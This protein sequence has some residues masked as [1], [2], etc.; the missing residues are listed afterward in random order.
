MNS[1]QI[2]CFVEVARQ[3]NFSKAADK[4]YLPQPTVSRYISN[5]EE[6]LGMQLFDRESKRRI[7]LTKEGEAYYKLFS[8]F[9]KEFNGLTQSLRENRELLRFGYSTGWNISN[10]FPK[11][12][13]IARSKEPHINIDVEARSNEELIKALYND[14]LDLAYMLEYYPI[15]CEGVETERIREH[16]LSILYSDALP[17]ANRI[18]TPQDFGD[19]VFFITD[20]PHVEILKQEVAGALSQYGF[21]PVFKTTPNIDS[22]LANVEN[23][24]GVAL[25]DELANNLYSPGMK[26]MD[27]EYT[28]PICV[29]WRKGNRK[30]MA[31]VVVKALHE[32][33]K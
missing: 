32:Y 33:Y 23:G 25:L 24:L 20:A 10:F 19:K 9:G 6:E 18:L 1:R 28:M 27:I 8:K 21:E 3:L 7:Q 29:A 31:D 14:E 11:V 12:I 30:R 15:N 5:L 17:D 26:H 2:E 13:S 22:T 16:K 4:L